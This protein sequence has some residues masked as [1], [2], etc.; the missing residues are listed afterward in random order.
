MATMSDLN[1]NDPNSTWKMASYQKLE[2]RKQPESTP[3]K[4]RERR[5]RIQRAFRSLLRL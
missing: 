4:G 5:S 2:R 3:H 1:F